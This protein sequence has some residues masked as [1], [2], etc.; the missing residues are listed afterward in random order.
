MCERLYTIGCARPKTFMDAL[1][2]LDEAGIKSAKIA[3]LIKI[4]YFASY[5]NTVEL[6]RV[7]SL[8]DFLI[9][10]NAKKISKAKISGTPLEEIIR[11]YSTDTN[12]KGEVLKSYTITDMPALLREIESTILSQNLPDVD[13][14]TKMQ[15]QL[16]I[17]GYIDL[18]TG[19][20][21]DRRKLLITDCV[22]LKSKTGDEVWGYAIFTRSVGSGKNSRLTVRTD[23][24]RKTPI[25]K[26]DILYA[27]NV[28]KNK[29]GYWYLNEY[30]KVG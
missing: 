23:V 14:K 26:G 11:K 5:G 10:G 22:P 21:E 27:D 30:H 29:S 4:D 8:F 16:E 13:Y 18:V 6:A 9:Q 20:A 25:A 12:A 17:L 3:P 28:T 15:N 19:R 7:L 24:Y 2:S 1:K